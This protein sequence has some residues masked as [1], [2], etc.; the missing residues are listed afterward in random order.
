MPFA[1]KVRR[2][3]GLP[4]WAVGMITEPEQAEA[5]VA[6]GEADMVAIAR[7]MMFDPRWAWHAAEA[8]GAETAYSRMYLRCHPSQW[9]KPSPVR[10]AAE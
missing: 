7:G 8:L 4:T 3:A 2:E 6:N 5:I 10:P 1:A 9:R